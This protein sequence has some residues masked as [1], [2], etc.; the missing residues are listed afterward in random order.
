VPVELGIADGMLIQIDGLLKQAERVVVRGN[1]RLR[2]GQKVIII[3]ELSPE[4]AKSR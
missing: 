1:E 3:K 2:T 4:V